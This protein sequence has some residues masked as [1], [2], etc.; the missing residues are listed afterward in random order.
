MW[1]GNCWVR[2]RE[3]TEPTTKALLHCELISLIEEISLE[4]DHSGI[5]RLR[6]PELRYLDC[7]QHADSQLT[8]TQIGK[9]LIARGADVCTPVHSFVPFTHVEPTDQCPR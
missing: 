2:V 9:L 3:Q 5:T 4:S 8:A 1:F 6:N 7:L